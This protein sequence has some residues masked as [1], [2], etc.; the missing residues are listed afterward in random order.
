[1]KPISKC[2][3]GDILMD[4]TGSKCKVLGRLGDLIFRSEYYRYDVSW[5]R[6]MTIQEAEKEGWKVLIDGM[7]PI[8]KQEAERL[9]GNVKIT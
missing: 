8:S 2:T 5:Y 9:L 7:E 4:T 1:M 3:A 6:P